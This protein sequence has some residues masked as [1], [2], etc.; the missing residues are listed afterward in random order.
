MLA[1]VDG[2]CSPKHLEGT[3]L[4]KAALRTSGKAEIQVVKLSTIYSEAS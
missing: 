2:K 3:K 4:G 1:G